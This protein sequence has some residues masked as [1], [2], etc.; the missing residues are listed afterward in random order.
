MERLLN[1][2]KNQANALVQTQAQPRFGT[3]TS[4]D[5]DT[6]TA[7]LQLQPEGVLSGWLPVLSSWA[8]AGWGMICPPAPGDQV[9]VLAQ[10]GAAE[11]GVIVGRIFSSEQRPPPA[12]SGELWLVHQSGSYIKL[13]NDGTVQ[14]G[15]D[16]HVS[17]DVYDSQGSLSRLRGHYDAHTHTDSRGVVTTTTSQPD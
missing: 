6:G 1:A 11:H 16:L 5:P 17:G 12:P 3:I 10:E 7:R 14:I 8:G 9:L 2:I 15:G 4:I 13:L